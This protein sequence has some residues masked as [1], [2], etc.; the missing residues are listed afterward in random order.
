MK[1]EYDKNFL[2]E[3]VRRRQ[4]EALKEMEKQ[5]K[6]T[7]IYK[8]IAYFIVVI[9]GIIFLYYWNLPDYEKYNNTNKIK[10]TSYFEINLDS[11]LAVLKQLLICGILFIAYILLKKYND[12]HENIE[13]QNKNN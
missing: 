11:I 1:N 6:R 12:A 5:Q 9:L 3:A 8:R 10:N 7:Q 13:I 2:L 4:L